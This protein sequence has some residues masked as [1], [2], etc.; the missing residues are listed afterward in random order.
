MGHWD[1]SDKTSVKVWLINLATGKTS[2][3]IVSDLE[4]E[5]NPTESQL[6]DLLI[7]RFEICESR[8]GIKL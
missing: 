8:I 2:Q 7:A 4:L 5:Q 3:L 6:M 1:I